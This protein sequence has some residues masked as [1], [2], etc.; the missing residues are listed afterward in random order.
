[1]EWHQHQPRLLSVRVGVT[2]PRGDV[3]EPC[4]WVLWLHAY[5][6]L[7]RHVFEHAANAYDTRRRS[8]V[9]FA[10]GWSSV[11]DG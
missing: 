6:R 8:A 3:E 2:E 11:W 7:Q 1:M 5:P 10:S 4:V 9:A